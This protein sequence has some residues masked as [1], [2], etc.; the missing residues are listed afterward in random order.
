MVSAEG[1]PKGCQI[2]GGFIKNDL[3]ESVF[4]IY[5]RKDLGFGELGCDIFDRGCRVMISDDALV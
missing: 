4:G 5:H 2:A 3:Q 1:G